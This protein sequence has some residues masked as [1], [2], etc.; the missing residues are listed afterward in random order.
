M[1]TSSKTK[2]KTLTE[3]TIKKLDKSV[4]TIVESVEGDAVLSEGF[5]GDIW[6][7]LKGL[8]DKAK[9]AL[10]GGWSKVKAVWSEF[11]D[12]VTEVASACK[13]GFV[14]AFGSFADKAKG[15]SAKVTDG[16]KEGL[17]KITDKNAFLKEVK[18][19]IKSQRQRNRL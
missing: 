11:K 5:F 17:A 9:E 19:S 16:A 3:S 12:L 8:G 4:K 6:D 13:D 18:S 15:A 2:T 7:G 1:L 10:S 14:K